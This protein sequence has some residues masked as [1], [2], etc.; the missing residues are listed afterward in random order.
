MSSVSSQTGRRAATGFV[1]VTVFLDVLGIGLIAPALPLFV[2]Q[3]THSLEAQHYWVMVLLVAYGGMQFCFAPLLGL[4]SDRF[5]RRPILLLSIFGLGTNFFITGSATSLGMLF[6]ARVWGGMTASSFSVAGAYIADV[7]TLEERSKKMGLIGAM[8]GLG[9]IFGPLLGALLGHAG[10]RYP[11]Y[12]AAGLSLINGLYGYFVLPESLPRER[13]TRAP[14]AKANPFTALRALGRLKGVGVLTGVYALAVLAQFIIQSTW[15]MYTKNRFGWGVLESGISLAVVGVAAV[16]MQG[17]LLDRLLKAVGE[18]RAV[19]LGLASA[20]LAAI[21]YGLAPYG[22][23]MY[24]IIAA[25]MLAFAV[26]PSIQGLISRAADPAQQGQTMGALNALSSVMT[27]LG[28][29]VGLPLTDYGSRFTHEHW[30]SGAPMFAV[31]VSQG[32][33]FLLAVLHFRRGGGLV[34]PARGSASPKTQTL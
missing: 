17:F 8:F 30:A 19:M 13:R 29:L 4:L 12:A 26:G 25:N 20:T 1:L 22:W 27:V 9:F 3:F 11:F 6:V 31:A 32:L 18:V 15:V 5:G 7:T 10:H 14:L 34:P 21:A 2:G 23:M 16:L 24:L 28:P 33:G